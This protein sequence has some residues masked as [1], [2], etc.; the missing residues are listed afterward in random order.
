MDRSLNPTCL[1][2]F[3]NSRSCSGSNYKGGE[4]INFT[5]LQLVT[6]VILLSNLDVV[7]Y[8]LDLAV[9]YRG[10]VIDSPAKS[11]SM[12]VACHFQSGDTQ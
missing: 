2:K 7:H 12:T 6:A 10:N 4:P 1:V 11:K 3:V 8:G 9:G 5:Q